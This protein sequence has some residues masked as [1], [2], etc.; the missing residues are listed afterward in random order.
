MQPFAQSNA[1]DI[2]ILFSAKFVGKESDRINPKKDLL[3]GKII[4]RK[5]DGQVLQPQL[6]GKVKCNR[7]AS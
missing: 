6:R 3:V 7:L 1:R 2:L 5:L 4:Q